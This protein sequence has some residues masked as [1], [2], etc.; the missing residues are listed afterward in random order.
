M[1][2]NT[3]LGLLYIMSSGGALS[4]LGQGAPF[5]ILGQGAFVTLIIVLLIL[6]A[7]V[8][9]A[10]GICNEK[11][12]AYW[13]GVAIAMLNLALIVWS[14]VRSGYDLGVFL[15][16]SFLLNLAFAIV[17]VCLLL[18]PHSRSYGRI[19]FH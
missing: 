15:N 8:V 9:A 1:Y 13:L 14:F 12:K 6:A 4:L 3:A 7:P 19:W 16:L 5:S 10:V 11:K 18:H 17:L 2:I